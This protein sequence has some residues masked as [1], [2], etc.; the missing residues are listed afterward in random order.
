M[1]Q[2]LSSAEGNRRQKSAA[3]RKTHSL[4]IDMTPMVDL[5][6]LLIAFFVMT[7]EMAKPTVLNLAMP[8]DGE[9]TDL[10]NSCAITVLLGKNHTVYYYEGAWNDAIETNSIA[11]TNLSASGLRS[12]INDKQRRLDAGFQKAGGRSALML[13]IKPA[14]GASYKTVVDLLDEATIDAVKKYTLVKISSEE[15]SWLAEK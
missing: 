4:R 9:P 12:I 14:P 11:Q 8:K 1:A 10:C 13:L 7:A 3:K 2:L 6:F 15:L 5:G